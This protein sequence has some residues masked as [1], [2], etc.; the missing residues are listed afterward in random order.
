MQGI[1]KWFS[2]KK[3]FGFIEAQGKDYFVH[4]SKVEKN[5]N[6]EKGDKVNFEAEQAP[7]GSKAVKVKKIGSSV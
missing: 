2:I 3:G 7:K 5:S 1:V 6:L 4:I